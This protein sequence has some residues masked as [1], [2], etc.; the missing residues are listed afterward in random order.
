MEIDHEHCRAIE[1][2]IA[3]RASIANMQLRIKDDIKDI[4]E[5]MGIKASKLGRI[6][7]MVEKERETGDAVSEERDTLDAVETIAE[8]PA[9][10]HS[11]DGLTDDSENDFEPE[12][13]AH[14]DE[15]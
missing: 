2:I 3:C 5:R 8:R 11:E 14:P 15:I 6:I 1:E 10:G 13:F 9:R 12:S 4:A 7:A